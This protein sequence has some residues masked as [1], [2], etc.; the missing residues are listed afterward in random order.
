MSNPDPML[1]KA[2][3]LRVLDAN[4]TRYGLTAE[5]VGNLIRGEGFEEPTSSVRAALDLLLDFRF[6]RLVSRPLDRDARA[7][8]IT[9]EGRGQY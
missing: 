1:L 9:A 3:I 5:A 6:V 2:A 8:A 7:F 4:T